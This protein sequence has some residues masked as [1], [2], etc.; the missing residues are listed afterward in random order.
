MS[1][2]PI[3]TIDPRDPRMQDIQSAGDSLAQGGL[4]ILPTETVY[5]IACSMRDK[6]AVQRLYEVKQRPKD[7]PFAI[8]LSEKDIAEE[9]ASDIPVCA[10][11][12][13]RAFWPGPLT[14]VFKSGQGTV[15]MR[16]PDH[17]VT[18]R[19]LTVAGV[20]VLCPSANLAGKPA[21]VTVKDALSDLDGLADLAVDAGPCRV[22]IESSVVDVTAS[23]VLVLR[24]G[25]VTAK[26]IEAVTHKKSVLFICTGNSC[27]SV[28]AQALLTSLLKARKRTDVEV[29]SAG[30]MMMSGLG[31][32]EPTKEL[33][34]RE[35]ISV[36]GH[37]SQRVSRDMVLA[38]DLVLVMEKIHEEKILQ[39]APQAKN[40]VFLLKEFAKIDGNVSFVQSSTYILGYSLSK[41]S[42]SEASFLGSWELSVATIYCASSVQILS[43]DVFTIFL[44]PS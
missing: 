4:V 25:A 31:A 33:L 36:A 20:P 18:L 16:M 35:G 26:E 3:L 2:T 14:I 11:K 12:L 10:Y 40:R 5:G 38:A 9:L 44:N 32:S 1:K 39:I 8:L 15:G 34:A 22:G 42:N 29:S 19:I 13:M 21:P 28:M 27:R 24:E 17:S 37:R 7:K 6:K 23:A 41:N 43:G 30:I